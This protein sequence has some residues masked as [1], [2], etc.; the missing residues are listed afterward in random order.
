MFT[1]VNYG[2]GQRTRPSVVTQPNELSPGCRPGSERNSRCVTWKIP[3]LAAR[4]GRRCSC[5]AD[6][7]RH[8]AGAGRPSPASGT[9]TRQP[10]GSPACGPSWTCSGAAVAAAGMCGGLCSRPAGPSAWRF[11]EWTRRTGRHHHADSG[12]GR[13]LRTV[14]RVQSQMIQTVLVA[15]PVEA[16][17]PAGRRGGTRRE[18]PCCVRRRALRAVK[19]DLGALESRA[20]GHTG[21]LTPYECQ[22]YLPRFDGTSTPPTARKLPS[23]PNAQQQGQR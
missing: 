2:S 6:R 15:S 19:L 18:G 20:D 17:V 22:R 12:N 10:G 9:R 3:T 14:R 11:T 8:A 16:L 4:P 21:Y 23:P 7:G 5:A 1:H 13:R